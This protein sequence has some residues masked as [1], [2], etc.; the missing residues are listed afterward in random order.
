VRPETK[1][2]TYAFRF[3]LILG[4]ANFF[5]DFAYEGARSIN[6]QFL[7]GLGAT[8]TVVGFTAGFGELIGYGLRS[9]T[10]IF[11]DRSG[12]YWLVVITGYVIN[13]GAIPALALAGN[14]PVAA[15]L[16]M[17]ERTGRAIRKPA[18]SAM[19]SHAGHQI[20]HGWVFGLND[21]MDQAGATV[22][23]LVMALVILLKGG[24]GHA[25]LLLGIPALCT[26]ATIVAARRFMPHPEHL[27]AGYTLETKGWPTRYWYYVA[28]AACV[29]VGFADFAL[30]GYHL[31]TARVVATSLIPVLYAIAM[32]VGA[33]G[34]LILG[35][36]FDRNARATVL[37]AI[38][39]S[40]FFAPLVFLGGSVA[41][42]AGMILWGLGMA[43][44]ET[45]FKPLVSTTVSPGKRA[46]G[47]GMFDTGF[48]VAWFAGSAAMG[49]LYGISIHAVVILSVVAQLAS[50]PIFFLAMPGRSRPEAA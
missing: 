35:R 2:A 18:M 44:Q 36:L 25:Y 3:V 24:Y 23:P 42:I 9:V 28:G 50:L 22:G 14:W 33:I 46:T 37:T 49:Y 38:F 15:A 26:V 11:S 21:A 30:I 47:F 20:G 27:S 4:L 13:M 34:A 19:L 43:T 41:A 5:A 10:G 45:V 40:A 12:R 7:A 39:V 31:E 1:L 8:S 6:G 32:S 16:I 48:G 17:A 29:A